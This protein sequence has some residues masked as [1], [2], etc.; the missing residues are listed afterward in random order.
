MSE[1]DH[2][3]RGDDIIGQMS[4]AAQALTDFLGLPLE[5]KYDLI[6]VMYHDNP[7]AAVGQSGT[8]GNKAIVHRYLEALNRGDLSMVDVLFAPTFTDHS[9]ALGQ[10]PTRKGFKQGLRMLLEAFP[11]LQFAAVFMDAAGDWVTYG[12]TMSG[13]HLG[14]FKGVASTGRSF[15]TTG[16]TRY[17]LERGKV[18]ERWGQFDE[19]QL[20]EQLDRPVAAASALVRI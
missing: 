9:R 2:P 17:R 8:E 14:T 10:P 5:A 13:T 7:A 3:R 20:W 12:F 15:T 11:D 6:E 18:V 4:E 1:G 16:M 19:Q